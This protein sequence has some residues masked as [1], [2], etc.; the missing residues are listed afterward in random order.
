MHVKWF[1][2]KPKGNELFNIITTYVKLIAN[3]N[4]ETIF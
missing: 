4:K 3:N 2:K 1:L